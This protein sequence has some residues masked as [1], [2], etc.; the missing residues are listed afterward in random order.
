M[1][2]I[3]GPSKPNRSN[4]GRENHQRGG[5][6]RYRM[7]WLIDGAFI[8]QRNVRE[9]QMTP[10]LIAEFVNGHLDRMPPQSNISTLPDYLL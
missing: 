7:G 8:E 2:A 9:D 4:S 10:S 3:H 5:K 6:P 1:L